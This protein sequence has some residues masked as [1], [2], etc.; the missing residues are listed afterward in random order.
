M[1]KL[2][3]RPRTRTTA[4][5]LTAV[6]LG[7]LIAPLG[8]T[9]A[10]FADVTA[11]LGIQKTA[12]AS[13]VAPGETFEYTLA[14]SCGSITD[15]GCRDAELVD[16]VPPEFEILGVAVAQS[17][18]T[19]THAISGQTVT[20]NFTTDLGDG[21]VGIADN[22]AGTVTISVRLRADTPYE[23]NGIP[24]TNT[25]AIGASNADTQTSAVD[26][27][28][29]VE[30]ALATKTSKSFDPTSGQNLP[31][32]STNVTLTGT[33]TSN[34]AV[35][36]LTISD[37]AD[38]SAVPNPF[39]YLKYT[40][41][42]SVSYPAGAD[43][44]VM[45]LWD[46]S[47]WVAGAP[48]SG[49]AT[50][51]APPVPTATDARGIRLVF[52]SSDSAIKIEA[53]AQ[54][55]FVATLKQRTEL[56]QSITVP[57]TVSS[58]VA[59]GN[60]DAQALGGADYRIV[61]EPILVE[62]TKAFDPA[63][64]LAGGTST[65]TLGAANSGETELDT[66]AIREPAT[67]SFSTDV[68]F[69]GFTGD[70]VFPQGAETGVLTYYYRLVPGGA[71]LSQTIPL[72][73]G[74]PIP[75]PAPLGILEHFELVFTDTDGGKIIEGANVHVAFTVETDAA[76]DPG[77]TIPN[78]VD[79]TGTNSTSS[80]SDQDDAELT[81]LERHIAVDTDKKINPGQLIGVPGQ[82]ALVQLP[83]QLLDP[84]STTGAKTITVQDP[85]GTDAEVLAS[86]WWQY[87]NATAITKTD[88]PP[89]SSLTVSYFDRDTQTWIPLQGA[90]DIQGSTSFSMDIPSALQDSIGGLRFEYT[91]DTEF[92]P[93]TT[94]QPNFTSVLTQSIPPA[95]ASN[96]LVE[97]CSSAAAT[98]PGVPP[99][100]ADGPVPCPTIELIAPTPG[101][102]DLIDKTW[103]TDVVSARS[104]EQATA[105]LAWSTGGYNGL[106]RVVIADVADE[107]HSPADVA[108]SV[109]Q[110]FNLVAVDA[111]T[112]ALDPLLE[113]DTVTAV[114]LWNGSSWTEAANSPCASS[115]ACEG[116]LPRIALTPAEQE[117]TT[118]VRLVFTENTTARQNATDIDA[119]LPGSGVASS[120]G[121]N[122]HTDLVFQVRDLVRV[123]DS[124]VSPDPVLGSRDY[125]TATPGDVDNTASAT[126][127]TG[128][129]QIVRDTA[130][131]VISILDR[132]LNTTVSKGWTGGPMGIPPSGTPANAYP[133]GRVTIVASNATVA[134]V[135]TLQISDPAP[136]STVTPF[137]QF[138]LKSIVSIV[139]PAGSVGASTRV[140]LKRAGA[141]ATTHSVAQALALT[142]AQLANVVG[143]TVAYNGRIESAAKGTVTMDLRL[144]PTQR[145]N[146]APVTVTQSPVR[147]DA[148][149]AVEDL[150]GV[151]G[152]HTVTDTDDAAITLQDLD[153]SV[154]TT[155]TFSPQLQTAPNNAPILMTLSA[156]PG[157]S[158]R[159]AEMVVVDDRT[160]F[161]NAF[162]FVGFDPS[163]QL[164]API[165]RV[166]VDAFTGGTFTAG[167]PAN[168]LDRSG[169]SWVT[170]TAGTVADAL[171]LPGTVTADEVQG[172]R[173]TFT[174]ADGSQWENPA[175]PLQQMP[176]IVERRAQF[177]SGGDNLPT[178]VAT[179][180]APGENIMGP[181]GGY[182]NTVTA[183]VTSAVNGPGQL[184]LTAEHSTT[185]RA[186]YVQPATEVAV[187]KGPIG[188]QNPGEQIPFTLDVTNTS[189]TTQIMNPVITDLLP[190]T[191]IGGVTVPE[192]VF[193][194]D[195]TDSPYSYE[196]TPGT[197][198]VIPPASPM[199]T[200]P[201]Q[202]RVAVNADQTAITFRFP[203][204]SA[205]APGENYRITIKLMFRPGIVADT[206]VQ[207][208]FEV[209]SDQVFTNCNG[210]GGL[211]VVEC[212]A[213]TT[214]YP[215]AAG[216]LRGHKYV[217]ADDDELG[218][219]NVQNP[220][221]A[222]SCAPAAGTGGFYD[223]PCVPITKPGATETWLERLQNSGTQP[224]DQIV[225]IDRLPTPGDIGAQVLLPRGSEWAPV[226]EGNVRL[227]PGARTP[228]LS[229]FYS[230]AVD[231]CVADL[232][233][234][235]TQCDPG[236]WLPLTAGVDPSLVKHVKFVFD[237]GSDPLL[238]GEILGYTFQTRTPAV[239]PTSGADTIAWNTVAT[240]ARTVVS[241]GG[242]DS[243]LPSEGHRVGVALA[244]GSLEVIKQ[245][246]GD[247]SGYAPSSFPAQLQCVS[248]V[249]TPLETALP[250][251]DL[252]LVNGIG[253]QVDGLPWGA[254]CELIEG[255]LGQTDHSSTT[256][257][258]GR[259]DEPLELVTLTNVY[260]LAA[261]DIVKTID[262]TAVD[263]DG[264]AVGYGPFEVAVSCSFL[265]QP[266]F[267]TGYSAASPMAKTIAADEH[268]LLRGLPARAGCTVTET[269]AKG[270][271][272]IIT[273]T[274]D[275]GAAPPVNGNSATVT[276][277]PLVQGLASVRITIANGFAVGGIA[278]EK[279]VT[280]PGASDF[281]AG[282]FTVRLVCT[283]DDASGSRTVW[284]GEL[285]LGGGD[286]LTASVENIA[287]GALCTATETDAGGADLSEVSPSTPTAVG[288]GQ[289]ISFTVTN[290]FLI[291][292]ITVTK[293]LTG[294]GASE[295]G[296]R[297][298]TV[299]LSCTREVNGTAVPVT[300]PGGASRT[301]SKA[302]SLTASYATLPLGAVCTLSETN[303]GGAVGVEIT[304]NAGDP[305]LG[306]VTVAA[307]EP[308][309]I[310]VVN[311]FDA[312]PPV[313]PTDLSST[314][315]DPLPLALGALAV[316][317]LGGGLMV[318][319]SLRRRSK[320]RR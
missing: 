138:N 94:L 225:T 171:K 202:V 97:N 59:L 296:D 255:D 290:T 14:V 33:N 284:D 233:P 37:P 185:A 61:T 15:V 68:A 256:A 197:G 127:F 114:E 305:L 317:L 249:G 132:P 123:E 8:A 122:R 55:G 247:A 23:A 212:A 102:G 186:F 246:T 104:H 143:I 313:P 253:Q 223:Y 205:L 309:E 176:I 301:L 239:S 83:T 152:Q 99:A 175:N 292:A 130:S 318:V 72:T 58:T 248:A 107:P 135:D 241:S 293:S 183:D 121:N 228:V 316:L 98:A 103:L 71:V 194:P 213:N 277:T 111:I 251:I 120:F 189:T 230:S 1:A 20:V 10:A 199:P 266:V 24:V 279:V 231:P 106:E 267:A 161:W 259:S 275:A 244:T 82:T 80:Q 65:V 146:G 151:N 21:T 181:G 27:T 144:R 137:E 41:L 93:G 307:G 43:T 131:D 271:T 17:L 170:G 38:P 119:P 265:G 2:T 134:R 220:T 26:V 314:G 304:P 210:V 311:T 165:T 269:D 288:A 25:A 173:F 91:S 110:A 281:G 164:A 201:S 222:A 52:S 276:L 89:D 237:F 149:S 78:D 224:L 39:D 140:T 162:D 77:A 124:G 40:A 45:E 258:V 243:V 16:T 76:L 203:D 274:T 282:P 216:A 56:Q 109:Y 67:G 157:G 217:Q 6:L 92:P 283:L 257:T 50:P 306:V 4:L 129:Q 87:F 116:T 260:D 63:A 180:P 191:V 242:N 155:K 30:L 100:A 148:Q 158:A 297:S 13:T 60:D 264:T 5:G 262:S 7:A 57:N 211:P 236:S 214:V 179:V 160:T 299:E 22:V 31:D 28:P 49:G 240:G 81:I 133:T 48:A 32:S 142:E 308:V 298:F 128:P 66:L 263:Q 69:T 18:G 278:V 156:R 190:T 141:A 232:R 196:L 174:R 90:I 300:V 319:V 47:S 70:V 150:G 79:V 184:P 303:T 287:A 234:T 207:N 270:A 280:G 44:V 273:V 159:T 167:P 310:S 252:V 125:N 285:T 235:G 200:D 36:T 9:G 286:P 315:V 204:G 105:E 168:G 12:S 227:V 88:V 46:G 166:Q 254:E 198:S 53:G 209:S 84:E 208:A 19:S 96:V 42:T 3:R 153:I 229:S 312:T 206:Q 178:G 289:T 64:V 118:S 302:G 51:T 261:I 73:D 169:G 195:A 192:L 163:F 95:P 101:S 221:Q 188:A 182:T 113:Y 145:S 295:F 245:V 215:V 250:P 112:P 62:A 172:L 115:S 238:P 177:R 108:S 11:M 320:E 85:Q 272:P 34:A 193:D 294:S 29:A 126:G 139:E 117:S 86:E 154:V 268:W 218:L 291:G 219:R 136:G 226:W 75:T 54:G 35:D 147:N 187:V 74:T